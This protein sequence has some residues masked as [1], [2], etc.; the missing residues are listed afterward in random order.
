MPDGVD[1][2]VKTLEPTV[3]QPPLDPPDPKPQFE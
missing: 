2:S 1:V 3:H